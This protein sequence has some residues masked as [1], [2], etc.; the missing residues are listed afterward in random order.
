LASN[1]FHVLLRHLI[2]H[3]Q[4]DL[5]NLF[6]HI[7]GARTDHIIALR[8]HHAKKREGLPDLMEDELKPHSAKHTLLFIENE[9]VEKD[10][11]ASHYTWGE[12]LTATRM[13]K[14]S[15]F[16]WVDS[17]TLLSLRY[18]Q[19][20]DRISHGRQTKMNK[21][22]A[23]QITDDEKQT[24]ATLHP[25]FTAIKIQD[26]DY[27]VTEL[28][29]L[30]A[31]NVTSFTKKYAPSDHPRITKYLRTRSSRQVITPR[32]LSH[33]ASKR[34]GKGACKETEDPGSH[35]TTAC[36]GF[37]A[38]TGVRVDT[39]CPY[40]ASKGK[41]KG[42]SINAKGKGK[43]PSKGKGKGK[44]KEKGGKPS[45]KG[46]PYDSQRS[47]TPGISP[48]L[49][50]I[51]H[52]HLKCH[53][54]HTLGH[55]KPN[56]R[57]WLALQTSDTYK[58]RNSHEPKYQL[59]YDHL[60][61]SVLAPRSCQYC[62]DEYCDGINCKSPFDYEDYNEA[63]MFF[64][65]TLSS[66]VMNAK[67]ERPL[68]SHAPQTEQL[69]WY[70]DEDWGG[71]RMRTKITMPINGKPRMYTMPKM[72]MHTMYTMQK[73]RLT[74]LKGKSILNLKTSLTRMIKI[75]TCDIGRMRDTQLWMHTY[76]RH[77]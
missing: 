17:F 45:V 15:L 58:Q 34:Q 33:S 68:D 57:K 5:S 20:I 32:Q 7:K 60:E 31:Q 3:A 71:E 42:K 47:G 29:K 36:M 48:K 61:D 77:R 26:G 38:R 40:Q 12:I 66:L 51:N 14:I 72:R 54:C 24:I 30:L 23:R 69:Y 4:H 21:V 64:T 74:M 35:A 22:I 19:T 53:F 37:S 67:L 18:G 63:S 10:D 56:C 11:D 73:K 70:D 55:I 44:P 13:P 28:I 59:I 2:Q 25:A 50:E 76:Q 27:V 62:S 6:T 52:G 9:Y 75:A 43:P 65:Q 46:K 49:G 41:G 8:A 16:T 39:S 1:C